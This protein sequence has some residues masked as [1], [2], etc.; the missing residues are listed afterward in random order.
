[1]SRIA[2]LSVIARFAIRTFSGRK[3]RWDDALVLLSSMMLTIAFGICHK[4]LGTLYLIE[5]LFKK[6][7]VP[8]REE[9]PKLQATLK[10]AIIFAVMNWTSVYLIKFTFM[11]FFHP[12]IFGLSR[13]IIRFYWITVGILTVCWIYTVLN[14]VI[15][16][17]HLGASSCRP[18][19]RLR[20]IAQG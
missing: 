14:P 1:M 4:M 20:A 13:R 2:I 10:W 8:F 7:I 11:Y 19:F 16:C 18:L 12:L 3:I 9:V 6:Q 5:A 17:S 15:I